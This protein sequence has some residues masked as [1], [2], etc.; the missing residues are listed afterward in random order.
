MPEKATS[1]PRQRFSHPLTVAI[2]SVLLTALVTCVFLWH[3]QRM[4]ERSK[5]EELE[6]LVARMQSELIYGEYGSF[7]KDAI[8][9]KNINTEHRYNDALHLDRLQPD[10]LDRMLDATSSDISW[11]LHDCGTEPPPEKEDVGSCSARAQPYISS[12]IGL[13][14]IA[15]QKRLRDYW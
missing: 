10:N 5:V 12:S 2:V 13:V 14:E 1:A 3:S 15:L 7:R 8:E 11:Y 9:F 6:A 4:A